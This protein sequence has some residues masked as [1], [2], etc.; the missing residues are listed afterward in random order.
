MFKKV[1]FKLVLC[2]AFAFLFLLAGKSATVLAEESK[3][4]SVTVPQSV[5]VPNTVINQVLQSIANSSYTYDDGSFKGTLP[6]AGRSSLTQT[7][8]AQYPD[9]TLYNYTFTVTYT[10]TVVK[11]TQP[12]TKEVAVSIPYTISVPDNVISNVLQSIS[13]SS[14]SY[15][16]GTYRGT[17]PCTGIS[18]VTA[19]FVASYPNYNLYSY[20]F[21]VY[22]AGTVTSY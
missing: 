20:S 14:Y 3:V 4:V 15:D 11:Y 19:T 2:C 9:M 6:Y 22:Y 8:V 5:T 13:T 17:L 12:S 21:T 16:D 7:L 1:G 18:N 10:G